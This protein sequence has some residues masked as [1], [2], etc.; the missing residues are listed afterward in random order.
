MS[1][2]KFLCTDAIEYIKNT[3]ADSINY[4]I[5]ERFIQNMPRVEVQ[6][7]IIKEIYRIL[8]PEGRLLMCE[9]SAEGFNALNELREAVGLNRIP[10]TSSDN[11]TAIRIEDKDFESYAI[12]EL[13]FKFKAK[14]GFSSFFVMSRVLHPLLVAPQRPRFDAKINEYARLVQKNMPYEVGYGSNVLWVFEK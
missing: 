9:G 6:K 13:G 11:I 1:I 8:K 4:V 7:A 2:P 14:N 3:E 10:E 12:N 5:T